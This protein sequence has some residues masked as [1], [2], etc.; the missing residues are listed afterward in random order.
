[1]NTKMVQL[2]IVDKGDEQLQMLLEKGLTEIGSKFEV[3]SITSNYNTL[4]GSLS[5]NAVPVVIKPL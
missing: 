5:D 1:M 2:L 4:L 3:T